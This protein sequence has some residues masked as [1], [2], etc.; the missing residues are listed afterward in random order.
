MLSFPKIKLVSKRELS[1]F[2]KDQSVTEVVWKRRDLEANQRGK[3]ENVILKI[4][5]SFTI[6]GR[7]SDHLNRKYRRIMFSTAREICHGITYKDY[8]LTGKHPAR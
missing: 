7:N 2:Q 5:E 4:L 8:I 1:A 3:K 6:L